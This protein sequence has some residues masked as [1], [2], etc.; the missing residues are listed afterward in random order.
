M[1]MIGAGTADAVEPPSVNFTVLFVSIA[2]GPDGCPTPAGS[3]FD[4]RE[5]CAAD[6]GTGWY[7]IGTVFVHLCPPAP[8][9][10]GGVLATSNM[11]VNEGIYPEPDPPS[12]VADVRARVTCALDPRLRFV[13]VSR[14]LPAIAIS[15][16][17]AEAR[18][19]T[20]LSDG[21]VEV[22]TIVAIGSSLLT[23]GVAADGG[24]PDD[25]TIL[26]IVNSAIDRFRNPRPSGGPFAP[27]MGTAP[28]L[29]PAP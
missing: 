19:I 29:S 15:G 26:R 3:T 4:P 8:T 2:G 13:G 25:A 23:V 18:V 6:L 22:N 12:A 9:T 17:A 14:E 10:T 28:V 27:V 24:P 20:D 7:A 5:L 16:T 1:L 11:E 21:G